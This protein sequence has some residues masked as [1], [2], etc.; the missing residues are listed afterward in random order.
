MF[1]NFKHTSFIA[2]FLKFKEECLYYSTPPILVKVPMLLTSHSKSK[3]GGKYLAR[4]NA[5]A[6]CRKFLNAT[7][8]AYFIW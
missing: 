3:L 7:R 8:K 1:G 5:L 4:S 6:F 2:D